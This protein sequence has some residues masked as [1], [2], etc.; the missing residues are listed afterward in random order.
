V[1][2]PIVYFIGLVLFVGAMG[3]LDQM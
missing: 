1:V 2:S 3:A